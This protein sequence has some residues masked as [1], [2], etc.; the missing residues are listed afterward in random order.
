MQAHNDISRLDEQIARLLI[1]GGFV[2]DEH[3]KEAIQQARETGISLRQA[4]VSSNFISDQT[5]STFLSVQL[6]VPLVDLRQ[7]QVDDKAVQLVPEDVAYRY[8]VLPL[9]LDGNTLRVAMDNPQDMDAK[10]EDD[11]VEEIVGDLTE[12]VGDTGIKAGVI[13]EVG[14]SWPLTDN[15]RKSLTAAARAQRLTGAP[16]LIHPGRNPQAPLAIMEIV[17]ESGGVARRTLM[18]HID[19]TI[20]DFETLDQLAETGCY[21]EYDLFGSESTHYPLSPIDMPNDGKRLDYILHLRDEGR[22]DQV[23][24]AHDICYKT[25]LTRY[26]GHGY[27]H[28][29]EN[30]VPI[31]KRKG[32]SPEEISRILVDNTARAL[33]FE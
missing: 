4:L 1:E 20:F 25:R 28:I 6:R 8:K 2:S 10:S 11:I 26:G 29:L 13:G 33:A 27:A 22:L 14:C 18:S 12:G 32:L 7:V 24:M 31:M 3:V 19:R 5:Y 30:V 16:L 17:K 21:I 23:L 15:E 9:G